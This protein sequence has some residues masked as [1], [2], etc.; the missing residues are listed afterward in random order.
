[1][2][3][4][5]IVIIVLD[6]MRRDGIGVYDPDARTPRIDEFARDSVVYENTI[7]TSAWTIPSH[8]SFLTGK[9]Q[10]EHGVTKVGFFRNMKIDLGDTAKDYLPS[11]LKERGYTNV[12]FSSNSLVSAE[13]GF[14]NG[15]DKFFNFD[16]LNNI[17]TKPKKELLNGLGNSMPKMAWNLLKKMAILKATRIMKY[18]L[19]ETRQRKI[20]GFPMIKGGSSLV[21][22]L[23]E[24]LPESP[25]FLFANLMEMH[26]PYGSP[27]LMAR[28][29]RPGKQSAFRYRTNVYFGKKKLS[30]K[31]RKTL[32]RDYYSQSGVV[33]SYFGEI[34]D[35]LK[36]KNAYD[37]SL[38]ILLADHGQALGNEKWLFHEFFLYGCIVEVPLIIKYPE[39]S[40]K[41][42][43]PEWPVYTSLTGIHE[44]VLSHASGTPVSMPGSDYAFSE[45]H[46]SVT[47]PW[48]KKIDFSKYNVTP[49]H[50]AELFSPKKVIYWKGY[51]LV[52]SGKDGRVLEFSHNGSRVNPAENRET[53]DNMITE[54]IVFVG[55]AIFRINE[56][57]TVIS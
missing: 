31:A 54:M 16:Y 7:G 39:G 37:N 19:R 15:F 18:K 5:N 1:M 50:K 6:T 9:Y 55:N 46:N 17:Y 48:W 3:K 25:F 53:F 36:E 23:K 20:E 13:T 22:K 14:G 27:Q 42:T 24:E 44:V 26:E 30:L 47:A 41:F 51:R 11:L 28:K 32:Q 29:L 35:H 57:P 52:V 45:V 33:D 10:L 8:V 56:E 12:A 4:P 2:D 21:K 40:E 49:Y 34:I 43:A 38:I